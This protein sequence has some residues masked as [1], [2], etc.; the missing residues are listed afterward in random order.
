MPSLMTTTSAS[1]PAVGQAVQQLGPVLEPQGAGVEVEEAVLEP[2]RRRHA[3]LRGRVGRSLSGAQFSMTVQADGSTPQPAS[4]GVKSS[5]IDTTPVAWRSSARSSA[6][7]WPRPAPEAAPA[8]RS[9]SAVMASCAGPA[10]RTPTGTPSRRHQ[11]AATDL[12]TS[13]TLQASTTSGRNV[14]ATRVKRRP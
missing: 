5:V 12:A 7:N 6:S 4:M 3:L 11:E 9:A 13:G 1:P 2:C 10:P 14:G 8:R